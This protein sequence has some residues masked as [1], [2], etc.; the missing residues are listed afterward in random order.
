M[1]DD[2]YALIWCLGLEIYKFIADF[3]DAEK[4]WYSKKWQI[5][6]EQNVEVANNK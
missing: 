4:E 3:E 1:A 5:K 6:V 2:I